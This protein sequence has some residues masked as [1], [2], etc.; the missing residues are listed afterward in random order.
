MQV[1]DVL[2]DIL[3]REL[4]APPRARIIDSSGRGSV[5]ISAAGKR[6]I[7]VFVEIRSGDLSPFQD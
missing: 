4:L 5:G 3:D 6:G 2:P 1:R 7:L